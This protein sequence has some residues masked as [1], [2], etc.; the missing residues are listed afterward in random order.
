VKIWAPIAKAG[1]FQNAD[2]PSE[3]WDGLELVSVDAVAMTVT[4]A[5][6][7]DGWEREITKAAQLSGMLRGRKVVVK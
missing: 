6:P 5:R 1:R 3:A 2:V 4:A 7:W